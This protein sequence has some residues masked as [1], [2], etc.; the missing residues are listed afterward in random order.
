MFDF[1]K[2]IFGEKVNFKELINDGAT[3][4]DVRTKAEFQQGHIKKSI[5]IPLDKLSSSLKMLDRSK[6]I[7]TCCASGMRSATARSFLKSSGFS[8]VYNGGSWTSL[9]KFKN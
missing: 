4:I 7:I 8:E 5:N 1:F 2:N 6:P 9:K 3:I